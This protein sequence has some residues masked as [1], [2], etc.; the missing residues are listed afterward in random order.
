VDF[1]PPSFIRGAGRVLSRLPGANTI[2]HFGDDIGA[3][4]D[5][6][7]RRFG[8]GAD[9]KLRFAGDGDNA[10]VMRFSDNTDVP[11]ST[12]IASGKGGLTEPVNKPD[13]SNVPRGREETPVGT[14]QKQTNVRIQNDMAKLLAQEGY[15]IEQ[16]GVA[17]QAG[18]DYLI[19]GKKF[20][21]YAPTSND[22][23]TLRDQLS[24]KSGRN[25]AFGFVIDLR[26]SEVTPERLR[27]R[28]RSAPVARLDEVIALTKEGRFVRVWP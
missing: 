25:Q 22:P 26:R 7:A 9:G 11:G 2:R 12:S 24:A 23:D 10:S 21:A 13:P 19:S 28:L 20:E 5:D 4:V 8:R 3:W 17:N 15:D 27:E 14:S 18:A 16:I 6:L 1:I